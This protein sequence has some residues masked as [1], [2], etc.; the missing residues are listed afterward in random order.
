MNT[1]GPSFPSANSYPVTS[2]S[3][4]ETAAP[5]QKVKASPMETGP[6]PVALHSS[7]DHSREESL[8]SQNLFSEM[9]ASVEQLLLKNYDGS[10]PEPGKIARMHHGA[11]HQSREAM[12]SLILLQMRKEMGDP[13]AINFPDEY[14][15]ALLAT[16]LLHDSGREGEGFDRAEWEEASGDNCRQHLL[17][18][19]YSPELADIC[20]KAIQF[21][22]D[23]NHYPYRD[24]PLACMI[25]SLLHDADVLEVMRVRTDF[26]LDY[27]ELF[28]ECKSVHEHQEK[29]I[30]LAKSVREV[31]G[32]QGDLVGSCRI[33][34]TVDERQQEFAA[35]KSATF[36]PEQKNAYEYATNTFQ[37]QLDHLKSSQPE[38]FGTLSR[39]TGPLPE[40]KTFSLNSLEKEHGALG[41]SVQQDEAGKYVD[42]ATKQA[43][44]VKCPPDSLAARNE[45]LMMK[46]ARKLGLN[47]PECR[48]HHENGKAFIISDWHDNLTV[49]QEALS[50]TAPLERA[51]LLMVAAVLGNRDIIGLWTNTFV[52]TLSQLISVDWGEAGIFGPPRAEKRKGK[53]LF[54]STPLELD[55]L[56]DPDSALAKAAIGNNGAHYAAACNAAQ[57]FSNLDQSDLEQAAAQILA[58]S[59]KDIDQLIKAFG[60]EKPTERQWL[61]QTIHDRIVWL[62]LRFPEAC[63][64]QTVTPAEQSTIEASGI[65]G[66]CRATQTTDIEDGQVRIHQQQQKDGKVATVGTLRLTPEAADRLSELLYLATPQHRLSEKLKFFHTDVGSTRMTPELRHEIEQLESECLNLA[67]ALEFSELHW[68]QEQNT[69]SKLT[70]AIDFLDRARS[71]PDGGLIDFSSLPEVEPPVHNPPMRFSTVINDRVEDDAGSFSLTNLKQG[72]GQQNGQTGIKQDSCEL[73]AIITRPGRGVTLEYHGSNQP[74]A[75]T[76]ERQLTITVDAEGVEASQKIFTTLKQLKLDTARPTDQDLQE[77]YL[78]RL[79]EYYGWHDQMNASL[80][81]EL[82]ARPRIEDKEQLAQ[83]RIEYKEQFVRNQ[84]RLSTPPRW[85]HHCRLINGARVYYRPPFP[86]GVDKGHEKDYCLLHNLSYSAE[87]ERAE[88]AKIIGQLL[89]SGA[90]LDSHIERVRKGIKPVGS[91]S[92]S[93]NIQSGAARLTYTRLGKRKG[94]TQKARLQFH[95]ETLGRLD[96]MA[97]K[98]CVYAFSKTLSPTEPLLLRHKRQ[99]LEK[100]DICQTLADDDCNQ[101]DFPGSLSLLDELQSIRVTSEQERRQV[102]SVLKKHFDYLPDGRSVE[103]L[104]P[105]PFS[106]RPEYEELIHSGKPIASLVKAAGYDQF[107][108]LKQ[109]NPKLKE[110]RVSRL[111]GITLYPGTPIKGLDFLAARFKGSTI[112]RVTFHNCGFDNCSLAGVNLKGCR[113]HDCHFSERSQLN[114]SQLESAKFYFDS[115]NNKSMCEK[116]NVARSKDLFFRICKEAVLPRSCTLGSDEIRLILRKCNQAGILSC[117]CPSRQSELATTINFKVMPLDFSTNEL[118]FFQS[119]MIEKSENAND[120]KL[121]KCI[122]PDIATIALLMNNNKNFYRYCLPGEKVNFCGVCFEQG[123]DFSDI[124]LSGYDLAG[125]SFDGAVFRPEQLIGLNLSGCTFKNCLPKWLNAT[126]VRSKML[127]HPDIARGRKEVPQDLRSISDTQPCHPS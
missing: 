118:L 51:R 88:P 2:H 113:F 100:P 90:S 5:D 39:L 32:Q 107:E 99:R 62:A 43:W 30:S 86:Y 70:D 87:D 20:A 26:D 72:H 27:L 104:V 54:T 16:C 112:K 121:L 24:E 82:R 98:S 92:L 117:L 12:W 76:F 50:K 47:V 75:K 125:T 124:D 15:P 93:D 111:D 37:A 35:S 109:Q 96:I 74:D 69:F 29:I 78:N 17:D 49:G 53:G 83:Q 63:Q 94:N 31:I 59:C 40:Y 58:I 56:R 116:E 60:P 119:V 10:R 91:F 8:L 97:F 122:K 42:R 85:Q 102:L 34:G 110:G 3:V 114:I 28:N 67:Q 79:A 101:M 4:T 73:H 108:R 64:E 38:L 23:P 65:R 45:I 115:N 77:D 11:Q 13:Q 57:L 71:Q 21:K 52:N 1:N 46:L 126:R 61:R 95:P 89:E 6:A 25:R 9:Q 68:Q 123:A 127:K 120:V 103:E 81:A 33:I 22:D 66:Y 55:I 48:L 7:P 84:L 14:V 44:Y 106:L 18:A 80:P 41:H 19:R 105:Q 36:S